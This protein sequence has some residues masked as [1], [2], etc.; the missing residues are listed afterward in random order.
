MSENGHVQDCMAAWVPN[1]VTQ[2]VFITLTSESIL[3]NI[4]LENIVFYLYFINFL[5]G[6][7]I[8]KRLLT[9]IVTLRGKDSRFLVC[10]VNPE[11]YYLHRDSKRIF[12]SLLYVISHCHGPA[13]R[14]P[15]RNKLV[16]PSRYS[17]KMTAVYDR[18]WVVL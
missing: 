4:Q 11:K 18:N 8:H 12:I 17:Y 15:M 13:P 16:L 1:R 14:I 2:T 6:K 10:K 3:N 7:L 9:L 5:P